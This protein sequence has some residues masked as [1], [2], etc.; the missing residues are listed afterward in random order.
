MMKTSWIQ[1]TEMFIHKMCKT[2][3]CVLNANSANSLVLRRLSSH[4]ISMSSYRGTAS[5]NQTFL[6]HFY[7]ACADNILFRFIILSQQKQFIG[8]MILTGYHT[9]AATN[10]YWSKDDDKGVVWC[11]NMSRNTFRA[12]KR[13]LHLSDNN[14]LGN[15]KFSKLRPILKKL[16]P[17]HDV[18]QNL[19]LH[20]DKVTNLVTQV[21]GLFSKK[22]V[23]Q[24]MNVEKFSLILDETTDVATKK[25]LV[26]VGRFFEESNKV[27]K[28]HFV[29]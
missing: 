27:V 29:D 1:I 20:R 13:N 24:K 17:K 12:I 5:A 14:N 23:F 25:S 16:T 3:G 7:V 15:D 28:D 9:L 10:M 4:H 18:V 21:L 19:K 6:V 22:L 8:I 2:C 26:V 11:E